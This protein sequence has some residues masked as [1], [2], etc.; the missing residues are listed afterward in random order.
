M[1][2]SQK[3]DCEWRLEYLAGN[4]MLFTIKKEEIIFFLGESFYFQLLSH[5][6]SRSFHGASFVFCEV[7]SGIDV[8]TEVTFCLIC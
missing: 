7:S 4:G 6:R 2:V 8:L 3:R 1:K 5:K